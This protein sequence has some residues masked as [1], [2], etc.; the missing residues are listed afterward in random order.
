MK[1]HI[2]IAW[3]VVILSPLVGK[4]QRVQFMPV[5]FPEKY[6]C[7]TI[8]GITQDLNGCTWLAD[9][10]YG[11]FKYDGVNFTHYIHNPYNSN[12]VNSG[13][14]ECAAADKRGNIWIGTLDRG[15]DRL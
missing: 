11:L 7:S 2:L 10:R 3:C 13:N 4:C 1:R 5:H 12:S 9:R 6:Q 8:F 15:L 14:L